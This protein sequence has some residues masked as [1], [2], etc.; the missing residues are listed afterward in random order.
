MEKDK[1]MTKK[2]ILYRL[3]DVL[4]GLPEGF[5]CPSAK[6]YIYVIVRKIKKE[7]IDEKI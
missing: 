7:G 5:I 1:K 4:L 3:E 6:E 2:E